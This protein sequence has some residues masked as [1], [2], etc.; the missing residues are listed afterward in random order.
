MNRVLFQVSTLQSLTL[1]NYYG[2]VPYREILRHGDTGIGTFD[3]MD[4]EMITVDGIVYRAD[5]NGDIFRMNPET[6]FAPFG[7]VAWYSADRS[8]ELTDINGFSA[9]SR[10][11]EKQVLPSE[12]NLF[13]MA[14]INGSFRSVVFRSV[15]RQKEPYR[16]ADAMNPEDRRSF[17]EH[18]AEGTVIALRCP[19]YM[20][21]L[22]FPGWHLHFISADRKR[23]GHVLNLSIEKAGAGICWLNGFEMRLQEGGHFNEMDLS[24]NSAEAVKRLEKEK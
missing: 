10:E 13:H 22:N 2:F 20:E 24:E 23:G 14:V 17:E 12:A 15:K 9:V 6:S 16:S 21:N 5:A 3:G 19:V 1:G 4:G 11:L 18:P 8:F 7:C